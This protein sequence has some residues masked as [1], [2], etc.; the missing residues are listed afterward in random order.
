MTTPPARRAFYAHV[1]EQPW[2]DGVERKPIP[3][4]AGKP[5]RYA[6]YFP[7]LPCVYT[8]LRRLENEG[9]PPCD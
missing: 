4:A 5:D 3:T 6:Q 1:S 8:V 2:E 9:E 7:R